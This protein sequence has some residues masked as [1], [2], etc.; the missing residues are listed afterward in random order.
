MKKPSMGLLVLGGKAKDEESE[1]MSGGGADS[2]AKAVLKA[3]KADD[4]AALG[5]ALKLHYELC[6]SSDYE[7]DEE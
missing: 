7:S 5:E 2:A 1:G 6:Q 4:Y 3:I